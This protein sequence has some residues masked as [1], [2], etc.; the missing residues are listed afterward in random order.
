MPYLHASAD[1]VR[2]MFGVAQGDLPDAAVVVGEF[3]L[4]DCFARVR[5]AW[6]DAR[7]VEEH[8]LLVVEGGRRVWVSASFGAA[9]AAT[10]AHLAVRVGARALVMAGAVGGLSEFLLPGDV[11]VPS[12]VVGRDG[13]SARMARG[14]RVEPD[15]ALS[16]SLRADLASRLGP[17]AVKS[18]ALVTTTTISFETDS[19][20]ARWRRAGFAAVEMEC[21]AVLAVASRFG[22][23]GAG[24]FVVMDDLARKQ[25]VLTLSDEENLRIT[26]AKDAVLRAA[27]VAASARAGTI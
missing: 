23:P 6:P 27:V 25:T 26:A 11:L 13:V 3:S 7:E 5:T 2:R 4:R 17:S 16:E 14:G 1:D 19:D 22:V 24:A 21:A 12:L 10:F 18:G 9:M 8:T 15:A 20:I